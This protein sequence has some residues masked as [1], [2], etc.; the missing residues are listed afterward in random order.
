[1]E[2]YPWLGAARGER[3]TCKCSRH[4]LV[5]FEPCFPASVMATVHPAAVSLSS[6]PLPHH[7]RSFPVTLLWS[8]LSLPRCRL[9][10][11]HLTVW[12]HNN[13]ASLPAFI[14]GGYWF[15]LCARLMRRNLCVFL[16]HEKKR[17]LQ[18]KRNI[19]FQMSPCTYIP[20]QV[21]SLKRINRSIFSIFVILH[22]TS[23]FLICFPRN[24]RL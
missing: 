8:L 4:P 3:V 11:L 6:L 2:K 14:L 17:F 20:S 22:D 21:I 23:G 12:R 10:S 18:E 9:S 13:G 24:T 15:N 16:Y 7:R 5:F 1:M 19:R